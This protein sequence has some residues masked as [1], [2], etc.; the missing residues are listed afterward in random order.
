MIQ[1]FCRSFSAILESKSVR[2]AENISVE[3]FLRGETYGSVV[4]VDDDCWQEGVGEVW[5][6]LKLSD[7]IYEQPAGDMLLVVE[8]N[9]ILITSY[10]C[11]TH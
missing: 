6:P 9:Q 8:Q 10:V 11:T 5:K 7:I 3:K 1:E 2:L 4:G